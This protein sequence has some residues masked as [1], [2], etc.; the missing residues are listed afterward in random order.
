MALP[1]L[2]EGAEV[3]L[4]DIAKS[5]IVLMYHSYY[6]TYHKSISWESS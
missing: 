4:W 2:L 5:L 3:N 1:F 6:S